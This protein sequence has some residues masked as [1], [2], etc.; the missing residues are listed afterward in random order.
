MFSL[1][2][3]IKKQVKFS[4]GNLASV[5]VGSLATYALVQYGHIWYIYAGWLALI[6]TTI[7]NFGMQ[8]LLGV[9]KI[10]RQ[11]AQKLNTKPL[12]MQA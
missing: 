2:D 4:F 7:T 10:D 9:V 3:L 5:P 8:I 12:E 1:R 6:A 11:K